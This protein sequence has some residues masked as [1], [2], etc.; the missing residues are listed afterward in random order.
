MRSTRL[1][2][3]ALVVV[4]LAV[5]ALTGPALAVA[6]AASQADETT[7]TPLSVTMTQLSPSV[8]PAKGVIT[9]SGIVTNDSEEDW[10]DINVSPFVSGTPITTRD[11]LAEAAA[12]APDATVGDR[13]TDPGLQV[14]VGDLAP[15][16][17][18]TFTV[19]VHAD[20]LPITGDPGVYWIGVHA[21]GT[22]AAGRDLVADGR[23]R[24][25]IPLVPR[26]M[27][28][29]RTLPLSVVLPLRGRARRAADGSLNGPARWV[30]L[31]APEGRLTRLADF[32]A[33]AG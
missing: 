14:L 25:F 13:L 30:R 8:I 18:T 33:S 23:A 17:S 11:G 2:T 31:T 32:G 4:T 7:P 24:T 5:T 3:R 10:T 21:L 15:G 26:S 27:A 16:K 19:R 12:S 29:R 22:N 20:A 9:I 28:R 1:A 6:G